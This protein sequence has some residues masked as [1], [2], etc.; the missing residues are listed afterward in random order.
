MLSKILAKAALKAHKFQADFFFET[1]SMS[2]SNP[3]SRISL[4]IKSGPQSLESLQRPKANYETELN[5]SLTLMTSIF[6][7]EFKHKYQEKFIQIELFLHTGQSSHCIGLGRI[8]LAQFAVLA[9]EKPYTNDIILVMEKSAEHQAK[10]TMKLGLKYIGEEE[11]SSVLLNKIKNSTQSPLK[12][13]VKNSSEKSPKKEISIKKAILAIIP[14]KSQRSLTP[15]PK[16]SISQPKSA[17]D[18]RIPKE[19]RVLDR[20][21]DRSRSKS[22]NNKDIVRKNENNFGKI[23]NTAKN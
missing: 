11:N 23:A 18:P 22:G 17:I 7:E 3:S 10:I 8:D 9:L 19:N 13:Q 6:F 4:S 2:S 16:S 1:L 5:E 21:I 15:T 20:L 14:K 12:S